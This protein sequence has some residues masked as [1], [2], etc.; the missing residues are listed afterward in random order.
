M[1][2]GNIFHLSWFFMTFGLMNGF[3]TFFIIGTP[4]NLV[5]SVKEWSKM[6][7]KTI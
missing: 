4:M 7:V 6:D 2:E 1:K 5:N 3:S